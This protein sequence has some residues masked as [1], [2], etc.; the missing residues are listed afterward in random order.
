MKVF[1]IMSIILLAVLGFMAGGIFESAVLFEEKNSYSLFRKDNPEIDVKKIIFSGENSILPFEIIKKPIKKNGARDI[2]IAAKAAFAID[3]ESGKI[4]YEKNSDSKLSIA[5]LTKLATAVT[6]LGFADGSVDGGKSDGNNYDL[7]HGVE[8]SKAAVRE[9][10]DSAFLIVGEKIKAGDLLT[11]ML[12]ASSNDAAYALAEDIAR[13]EGFSGGVED[14]VRSM[15]EVALKE[16]MYNTHF[17]NSTG[18]DQENHYSTAKDIVKMAKIFLRRYPEFFTATK[19][20]AINIKSE[21]GKNNHYLK[22][23]NKL[24]GLM[25]GIEAGKTGYTEKAGETLLLAARDPVSESRII[26]V[27]IGADDRFAEMKK[28]ADWIWDSY[29]W[30]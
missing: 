3:E 7:S 20:A 11:M 12:V 6:I 28:M 16:G 26:A 9:E 24:L 10:G 15:N 23:T 19:Y 27:V 14:F 13:F 1:R 8:I 29:E 18:I 4:L 17:S 5:S 2:D 25:P 30:K 21:D 22:N